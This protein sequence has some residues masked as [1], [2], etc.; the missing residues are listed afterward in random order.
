M[1]LLGLRMGHERGVRGAFGHD[2]GGRAQCRQAELFVYG[3][4]TRGPDV[5]WHARLVGHR[6]SVA[7]ARTAR[8]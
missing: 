3:T 8:V 6:H 1:R 4:G 5:A 7:G 2:P